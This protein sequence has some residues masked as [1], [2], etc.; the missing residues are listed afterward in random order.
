MTEETEDLVLR[1]LRDIRGQVADIKKTAQ[2]HD[3]RLEGIDRRLGALNES[4]A[5]AMGMVAQSHISQKSLGQRL[6]EMPVDLD[7]MKERMD[8]LED[9]P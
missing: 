9:R 6:D 4:A 3:V 5:Y 7:R 8:D 1:L 2:R